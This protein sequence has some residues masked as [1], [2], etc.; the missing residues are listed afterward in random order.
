MTITLKKLFL[1]SLINGVGV[2]SVYMLWVHYSYVFDPPAAESVVYSFKLDK[3]EYKGYYKYEPG[4]YYNNRHNT[5]FTINSLGFRSAEFS[6]EKKN[7]FRILAIGASSTMGIESGDL[8][9]WPAILES[10]LKKKGYDVEVI[11]CGSSGS[12][13]E[14]HLAMLYRELLDYSPD[15]I[16]HYAARNNHAYHDMIRVTNYNKNNK[17]FYNF[18]RRQ[19]KLLTRLLGIKLFDYDHDERVLRKSLTLSPPK[20]KSYSN[21]MEPW[22]YRHF[23]ELVQLL[24]RKKV[25]LLIVS[26]VMNYPVEY[27]KTLKDNFSKLPQKNDILKKITFEKN[28]HLHAM[29]LD[30]LAAQVE[31]AKK[32][33]VPVVNLHENFYNG[34]KAGEKLFYDNVHLTPRG[35]EI[36]GKALSEIII[37]KNN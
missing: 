35:N 11:N 19:N 23:E 1:L 20:R 27:F 6:K 18:W 29:Q 31:I 2:F 36:I 4:T 30:F 17:L 34:L 5:S 16:I 28:W 24:K 7:K 14:N 37:L 32:Y 13:V 3:K 22:F 33:Q 8:D 21:P 9:T 25:P 12:Y 10:S 15:L 26:Q